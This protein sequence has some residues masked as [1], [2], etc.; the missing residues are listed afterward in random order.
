M[1]Y[2]PLILILLF[3]ACGTPRN[4]L[5]PVAVTSRVL[6]DSDDPAIWYNRAD[7]ERSLILGT[8]K[9]DTDGGIY[10]FDLRGQ[11]LPER[12]VRGLLRPNNVDVSYGMMMGDSLVD[13]AVCTERGRNTIRVLSLPD[14]RFLDDGGIPVFKGDSLRDPMG[15]ALYKDPHT[16]STSAF[17]S[18]KTGPDGGYIAQIALW[19]SAGTVRGREM[20][21]FGTFRGG[22][23]IE[24]IAVDQ[25]LGFVYYSDEGYGI[26][27]YHASPDS[28]DRELAV[29]G[30]AGFR[31]DHEG[32]SIY[33]GENGT[34]YIL[35]SD[36]GAN[37]FRVFSRNGSAGDLHRH[38]ELA[39]IP[40]STRESDGSEVISL[41]LG[42]RFPKGMFVAMS[43]DRTFQIYDWRD[44][45]ARI[46]APAKK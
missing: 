23:E 43:T 25:E 30:L 31:N 28:G 16:G 13:I 21:R 35:V 39:V 18:R 34:G 2:L 44:I 17:V 3:I 6:G 33:T 24:A 8:D 1:H 29:F 40:F 4:A 45:E 37:R 19:D 26:H 42:E 41:A 46:I 14:M 32:I 36:Q 38:E 9:H 5:E 7:P 22:K 27:K 12:T 11:E 15:I 20:R 10:V